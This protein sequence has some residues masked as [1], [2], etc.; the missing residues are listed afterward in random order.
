M[1][2]LRTCLWICDLVDTAMRPEIG[3]RGRLSKDQTS[4]GGKTEKQQER[5]LGTGK[6]TGNDETLSLHPCSFLSSFIPPTEC[7]VSSLFRYTPLPV[8]LPPTRRLLAAFGP[9]NTLFLTVCACLF[10][11][12]AR[13]VFWP[14][15]R[16]VSSLQILVEGAT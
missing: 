1:A 12:L 15:L 6:G 10:C 14:P 2:G 11:I 5:N 9:L 13:P 3:P 4:F 8:V 7:F 16:R